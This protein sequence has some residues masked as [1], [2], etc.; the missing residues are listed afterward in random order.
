MNHRNEVR[1][2]VNVEEEE[3]QCLSRTKSTDPINSNAK[4][5]AAVSPA[6]THAP[7]PNSYL[8]RPTRPK[9]SYN[10]N[11]T[12]TRFIHL[13]FIEPPIRH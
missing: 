4:G 13:R 2:E 1:S 9:T 7:T 10:T 8:N 11:T 3:D 6:S 5:R 12:Q